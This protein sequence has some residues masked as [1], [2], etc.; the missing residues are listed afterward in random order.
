MKRGDDLDRRAAEPRQADH[1]SKP[2]VT[3]D[4]AGPFG[5]SLGLAPIPES[6]SILRRSSILLLPTGSWRR[7]FAI[8]PRASLPL[9]RGICRDGEGR[10]I[11]G[12]LQID[13]ARK[14]FA[15]ETLG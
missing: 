13:N 11:E 2:S 8:C 6:G 7:Q 5:H 9:A 15:R 12:N 14:L 10:S 1:R 4:T 3:G